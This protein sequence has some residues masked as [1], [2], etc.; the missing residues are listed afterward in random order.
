[1]NSRPIED[2]TKEGLTR[3]THY[4]TKSRVLPNLDLK[5]VHRRIIW[6]LVKLGARH[7][8]GKFLKSSTVVGDTMKLH[9]HGDGSIAGA[10]A[11]LVNTPNA[12]VTGRGNW[13]NCFGDPPAA[14]RYTEVKT[15]P[16]F[17]ELIDES[18]FD[19]GDFIPSYDETDV[20][21]TIFQTKLPLVPLLGISGIGVGL[22]T[23][24]PAFSLDHIKFCIKSVLGKPDSKELW[25]QIKSEYAYGGVL[26]YNRIYP[27][28]ELVTRD[29]KQYLHITELPIGS[30]I[31]I[32]SE[33]KLIQELISNKII[34]VIDESTHKQISIF[35]SAPESI[36]NQI[37]SS[38]SKSLTENLYYYWNRLRHSGYYEEWVSN[39]L[40]YIKKR[41]YWKFSK[42]I[43]KCLDQICLTE[44]S[45][46]DK[47]NPDK[48]N[49][50][51]K[52]VYLNCIQNL[53][54]DIIQF[55]PKLE[56]F[57]L[58]ISSKPISSI[59]EYQ[60]NVPLSY[61]ITNEQ[62]KNILLNEIDQIDR[63]LFSKPSVITNEIQKSKWN[64][65]IKRY[66]NFKDN[67]IEVKFSK[68]SRLMNWETDSKI[69]IVYSN[70]EIEHLNEYFF[71][72][73]ESKLEKKVVG[74][75]TPYSKMVII[76]ESNKVHLGSKLG[77]IKEPIKSCYPA[78]KI[79]LDNKELV[80]NKYQV[81]D[82]YQTLKVLEI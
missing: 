55:L 12:L 49:E 60:Y 29:S 14:T 39:R 22:T 35:I 2:I 24:Y 72:I 43:L 30:S 58:R 32:L 75:Y 80:I 40:Q 9:P 44:L 10:L 62:V 7:N 52:N 46:L 18:M 23:Q 36:Q 57:Q 6:S 20:E 59:K 67:N 48:T 69:T 45:K 28:S 78:K 5:S 73:V 68:T 8:K 19:I 61:E 70:G 71:G 17:E 27:K 63:N 16:I 79:L 34:E 13:G 53:P 3:Y 76:T 50:I 33:S 11:H 42:D 31:A 38:C 81:I 41:E 74:F 25:R 37:L 51:S 77:S 1:M 15:S 82:Q 64:G 47:I 54:Q 21:P 56:E 66:I 4:I 65:S 26:Y